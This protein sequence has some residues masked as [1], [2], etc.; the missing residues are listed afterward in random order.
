MAGW[1]NGPSAAAGGFDRW[2]QFVP[3]MIA[4]EIGYFGDRVKRSPLVGEPYPARVVV[5]LGFPPRGAVL[6][7]LS[8]RLPT[9]TRSADGTLGTPSADGFYDLGWRDSPQGSL[10]E[11]RFN[12][13]TEKVSNGDLLDCRTDSEYGT[14]FCSVPIEV[15]RRPGAPS[16]RLGVRVEPEQLPLGPQPANFV[17][18]MEDT[19]SYAPVAGLVHG[20][21]FLPDAARTRIPILLLT[22]TPSTLIFYKGPMWFGTLSPQIP[23]GKASAF[24]GYERDRDIEVPF[25]FPSHWS[26]LLG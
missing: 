2:N 18:V 17:V 3:T 12:L 14:T 16:G 24:V 26:P 20:W 19:G 23:G 8:V 9:G 7:G 11:M 25:R 15:H 21:S 6:F 10:F 22:N 5:S 13:V 1:I 4:V